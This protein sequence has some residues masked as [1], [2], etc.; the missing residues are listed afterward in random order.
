M[1]LAPLFNGQR[2][3][4][5]AGKAC[6]LARGETSTDKIKDALSK[7]GAERAAKETMTPEQLAVLLGGDLQAQATVCAAFLATSV[8]MPVD[9][10][11][12]TTPVPA[13]GDRADPM[14]QQALQV[15]NDM[16]AQVLPAKYAVAGANSEIF[17]LIGSE[18]Q[19]RP[20]LS[21]RNYRDITKELFSKLS[22]KYLARLEQYRPLPTTQ[23]KLIQLNDDHFTF[24]TSTGGV[25]DYSRDG[26]VLRQRGVV[27]YG[28]G[29]LIGNA[30]PVDVAYFPDTE[31]LLSP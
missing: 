6:A 21:L 22:R 12:F 23:F 2:N 7:E 25:F 28:E 31:K 20:G 8:I 24:S 4:I 19:R 17:A 18:L 29:V 15:N 27:M 11:E 1:E 3:Y 14:K 5:F 13:A 30:Y 9:V 10:T 16:L 26:L